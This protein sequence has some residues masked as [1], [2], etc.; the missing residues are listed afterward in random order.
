MLYYFQTLIREGKN[1]QDGSGWLSVMVAPAPACPQ[2]R[3]WKAAWQA[4]RSPRYEACGRG[5]RSPG[6][7]VWAS[8]SPGHWVWASV[9]AASAGAWLTHHTSRQ[10]CLRSKHCPP[11]Q[12]CPEDV[13]SVLNRPGERCA[14]CSLSPPHLEGEATLE[15]NM[16][17]P[18]NPGWTGTGPRRIARVLVHTL[19]SRP[20]RGAVLHGKWTSDPSSCA[21]VFLPR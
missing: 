12:L 7:W 19:A 3:A 15:W 4:Q 21:C 18:R 17:R 11:G 8:R 14:H 13:G 1:N 10:A 20:G 6:H 9:W 16:Q 2:H 5:D